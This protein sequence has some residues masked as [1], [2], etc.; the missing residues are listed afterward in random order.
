MM[1]VLIIFIIVYMLV[2]VLFITLTMYTVY[3]VYTEIGA[4]GRHFGPAVSLV[5]LDPV[6]GLVPYSFMN[7]VENHFS[8]Y[9]YAAD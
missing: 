9:F 4:M 8:E 1:S 6:I 3:I 2:I 5:L 7:I